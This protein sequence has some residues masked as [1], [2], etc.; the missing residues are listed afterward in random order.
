LGAVVS[1]PTTSSAA[2][3]P[4]LPINWN[5]NASTH[6]ARLNQTVTVP[7]GKFIGSVDLL[8]GN[9]RGHLTLPP[10]QTTIALL[11]LVPVN[12]TFAIAETRPVTGHVNFSTF[13]V[14]TRSSFNINITRATA[15]GLPV[16]LVG[17]SCHTSSPISLS[18]GG[19]ANLT[20]GSTLTGSYAIPPFADCA[21]ATSSLNL[22]IPGPG[23]TFRA[24]FAPPRA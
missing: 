15:A 23:N 10:A 13:E 9:L 4:T 8:T 11:G 16:N 21:L 18:L 14:T 5:V 1:L 7:Q 17:S 6:I 22:L 2:T 24:T 3:D 19:K 20:T 12:A